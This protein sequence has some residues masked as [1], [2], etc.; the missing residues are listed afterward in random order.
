MR[1][2]L[3]GTLLALGVAACSGVK[4]YPNE[5]AKNLLVQSELE[6]GVSA[7]LDVYQVDAAC[8]SEYRGRVAL[9]KATVAVGIPPERPSYLVVIFDTSSFFGGSSST[10]AGT[11]LRPRQ[12]LRYEAR[13]RYRDRIYDFSVRE[14][15]PG[16]GPGR[17]LPRRDMGSC[18]RG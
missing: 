8:K 17:A 12:G 18:D 9:D 7:A 10:S 6:S 5:G 13:V 16:K 11:L 15:E 1:G 14:L 3:A 2:A 4:V